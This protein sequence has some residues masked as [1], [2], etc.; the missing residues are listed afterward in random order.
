MREAG[1]ALRPVAG[2]DI[3]DAHTLDAIHELQ[4]GEAQNALRGVHGPS[5]GGRGAGKDAPDS[6]ELDRLKKQAEDLKTPPRQ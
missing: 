4:R 2:I 5:A 1:D 6:D 3:V